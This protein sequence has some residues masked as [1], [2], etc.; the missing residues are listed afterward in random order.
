M[1]NLPPSK[2][3]IISEDAI[4]DMSDTKPFHHA[5][6]WNNCVNSK[7]MPCLLNVTTVSQL[8]F[9]RFEK[10]DLQ[11]PHSTAAEIR[12]KMKSRQIYHR[13]SENPNASF[14]LDDDLKICASINEA[15][16]NWAM[17]TASEHARSR[18]T[19]WG[20]KLVYLNDHVTLSVGPLWING[21]LRYSKE[22]NKDG[23]EF[24]GIQSVSMK[25]DG[26]KRLI[27]RLHPDSEGQHYCKLLSPAR[28]M[29]WIYTD[30]LRYKMGVSV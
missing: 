25:T 10:T 24:L 19:K 26:D 20:K 29:E 27:N 2:F 22:L 14:Q 7:E 18:F 13:L 30:G 21:K 1:A 6:V 8:V 23:E 15:A 16:F 9:D 12:V 17:D 4:H 11:F 28:A 3:E 5:H